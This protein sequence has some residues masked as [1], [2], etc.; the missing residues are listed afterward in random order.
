MTQ[1]QLLNLGINIYTFDYKEH[2]KSQGMTTRDEYLESKRDELKKYFE[3]YQTETTYIFHQRARKMLDEYASRHV[4]FSCNSKSFESLENNFDWCFSEL[5]YKDAT[6]DFILNLLIGGVKQNRRH[7]LTMP[8]TRIE[9]AGGENSLRN[10]T[11]RVI[12]MS[13]A[14]GGHC[15]VPW[16]VY[17]PKDH[18]RYFGTPEQYAD[19][20]G[21]IRA[22][23]SF[24]DAYEYSS[25]SDPRYAYSGTVEQKIEGAPYSEDTP[26]KIHSDG[27]VYAI[28][29]AVPQQYDQ[30]IVVHL[31]DWSENPEPFEVSLNPARFFNQNPLNIKLLV[32]ASYN[33]VDHQNAEHTKSYQILSKNM[34]LKGGYTSLIHIPKLMPWGVLVIEPDKSQFDG[35]WQPC[36]WSNKNEFVKDMI[37]ITINSASRDA[38]IRY[39]LD[40]ST[41]NQSS[42]K[43]VSPLIIAKSTTI[44]AIAFFPDGRYSENTSA[45]F[46]KV[47]EATSKLLPDSE[48]LKGSLLLWLAAD[49][50]KN[51]LSEGDPVT[52]WPATFGPDAKVARCKILNGLATQPPKYRVKGINGEPAIHFDGI[53]D[54]LTIPNYANKYLINTGFTVF[55]VTQSSN[56]N[57][58]ICGN[59][60]SGTGGSPRLYLQRGAFTYNLLFP[61]VEMRTVNSVPEISV[62]THDGVNTICGGTNG[63]FAET[64]SDITTVTMFGGGNLS[65]P[66]LA[67]NRNHA[68]RIAEI[69]IFN[70]MLSK[71]E[72]IGVEQYLS[73]KYSIIVRKG[74]CWKE[75]R[76][77]PDD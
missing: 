26:V 22:N 56:R 45:S 6:P 17:M 31:V 43:Y 59:G 33:R 75:T 2:L 70:R 42:T 7:V 37:E 11:R 8:K 68:G 34:V 66:F 39:T 40:G 13:Y 38:T 49:S 15:M 65:M 62:F 47:R 71:Q 55:M 16:D 53:D 51:T 5:G 73:E 10:I 32:P 21:F 29:R 41:L 1:E 77:L 14:C 61:N 69:L 58:G 19:L 64:V 30:P 35:V 9:E 18:P 76:Q 57:F 50:L 46:I 63:V 23:S 67:G 44:N 27:N 60:L 12:A 4:P 20:Y 54:S 74:S 72:R 24:F 3:K 48:P 52:E 25:S 28:I 36:I